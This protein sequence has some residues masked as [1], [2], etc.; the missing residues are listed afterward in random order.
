M[1]SDINASLY[2]FRHFIPSDTDVSPYSF[3]LLILSDEDE[4]TT[5]SV[6]SFHLI[7]RFLASDEVEISVSIRQTL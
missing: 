2:R 3:R 1:S 5:A 4:I 6:G 7:R